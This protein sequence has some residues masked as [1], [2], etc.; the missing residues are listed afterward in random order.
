MGAGERRSRARGLS[1]WV[2]PLG[3]QSD[4]VPIFRRYG[5]R[6]NVAYNL[7]DAFEI[8]EELWVL[9]VHRYELCYRFAPF[10][11]QE[12]FACLLNIVDKVEALSLKLRDCDSFH[13]GFHASLRQHSE[14]RHQSPLD[15]SVCE[16]HSVVLLRTRSSLCVFLNSP[17]W[18]V[19]LFA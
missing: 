1:L 5:R 2:S 17:R 11:D 3:T 16:N 12:W 18:A 6:L 10:C 15:S 4:H 8:T 13:W 14:H 7:K 9:R 19:C